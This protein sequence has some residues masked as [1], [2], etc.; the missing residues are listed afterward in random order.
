MR[1]MIE[2]PKFDGGYNITKVTNRHDKP[3][4]FVINGTMLRVDLP[5]PLKSGEDTQF[6]VE[7]NYQLHEQKV[8]GGRS[9]YEYFKEDD[10][11][12]Y[13][14]ASWFPPRCCLLRYY[15]LAK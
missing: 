8:L 1:N 14:V 10:N 7:W 15:G 2:T 3:L 5:E 11:Y 6:N 4:N 9:G 12:L 13:E